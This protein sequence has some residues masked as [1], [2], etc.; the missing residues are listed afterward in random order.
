[1]FTLIDN[2]KTDA[3]FENFC[4]SI[5]NESLRKKALNIVWYSMTL[6]EDKQK[7]KKLLSK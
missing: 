4:N 5:E 3:E 2:I 1:M 6:T 7:L